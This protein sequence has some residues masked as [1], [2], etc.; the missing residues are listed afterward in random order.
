MSNI[1]KIYGEKFEQMTGSYGEKLLVDLINKEI[2]QEISGKFNKSYA[3]EQT[4]EH[5]L[6]FPPEVSAWCEEF[7]IEPKI[8][9]QIDHLEVIFLN[10]QDCTTFQMAWM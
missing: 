10:P 7:Q 8:I 5:T 6:C 2:L 9:F 1:F 4:P 3:Q